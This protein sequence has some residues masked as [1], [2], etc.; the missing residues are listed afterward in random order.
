MSNWAKNDD[1]SIVEIK[2]KI[3]SRHEGWR[4]FGEHSSVLNSC[5]MNESH[6]LGTSQVIHWFCQSSDVGGTVGLLKHKTL[7]QNF[8]LDWWEERVPTDRIQS[9]CVSNPI[10]DIINIYQQLWSRLTVCRW[11]LL[12][13]R[14]QVF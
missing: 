5:I 3:I 1:P 2:C 10:R 6:C 9:G 12:L 14:S 11:I 7:I 8:L 4:V 13:R